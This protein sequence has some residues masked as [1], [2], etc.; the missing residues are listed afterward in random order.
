[1]KK[2][3]SWKSISII[4]LIVSVFCF[5][6][7]TT[8]QFKPIAQPSPESKL[9]VATLLIFGNPGKYGWSKTQKEM[10]NWISKTVNEQ[11]RDTG[12]YEVVPPGDVKYAVGT[13]MLTADEYWWLKNDRALIKQ[14]GKA[15]YADYVL[16]VIAD[17]SKS[18][19]Y[20]FDFKFLNIETGIL[21]S[22]SD[23]VPN[24]FS[25]EKTEEVVVKNLFPR[26]YRK[27]FSEVKGDLLATAMRKGRLRPT[28]EMKKPIAPES[29]LALVPPAATKPFPTPT[30]TI[31]ES[32]LQNKTLVVDKTRL[33]VHDFSASEQLH[34]VSLILSEALREE[35]FKLGIFSLVN[36]EN[37]VQVMQE[38]RLQ[39]SGLVDEKQALKLGKWLAANETVTGIFT[40]LGNSFILQ[41]KRT[42]ITTMSTMGFGTL[43]C[44][45]GQEE[46]LLA[47]L[48]ELARK[49]AG[50]EK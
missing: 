40:Q 43:K 33:V 47:G 35:L 49:I 39:Q 26:M 12:I 36:R 18:M 9:R 24:Q 45:A 2:I 37:L 27:L 19:F 20:T 50:L 30:G 34:V 29:N 3:A 6:T 15:L 11:L 22:V 48:P 21:Y 17:A 41:A 10:S 4:P 14:L 31:A 23:G 25:Y 16:V 46:E 5:N 38:L 44:T 32:G 13:Q 7:C 28:E 42:D 8:I 1:M